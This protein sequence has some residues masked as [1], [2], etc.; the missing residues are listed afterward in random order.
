M[1]ASKEDCDWWKRKKITRLKTIWPVASGFR[2]PAAP[3]FIWCK[4]LRLAQ[5]CWEQW[6]FLT[7]LGQV[8]LHPANATGGIFP[9]GNCATEG[10]FGFRTIT[11][12]SWHVECPVPSQGLGKPSCSPETR[13]WSFNFPVQLRSALLTLLSCAY[14]RNASKGFSR[15]S[16]LLMTDQAGK[17]PETPRSDLVFH[18]GRALLSS[19]RS[20]PHRSRCCWLAKKGKELYSLPL[21]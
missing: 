7:G 3:S 21:N 13:D 1:Q 4:Q 5:G 19:S 9:W 12:S 16:S 17:Q 20:I 10:P 11:W 15:F 2:S 18:T 6:N 8:L 14:G